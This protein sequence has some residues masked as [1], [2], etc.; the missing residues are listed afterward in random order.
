MEKKILTTKSL[1]RDMGSMRK[2]ILKHV[3]KNNPHYSNL[4][5]ILFE[6]DY[7]N[8]EGEYPSGKDL[9]TKTRLSQTQF[10][11]QLVEMYEDTK[12]DFIYKFPKTSTSFIVKNNGRY[13]VLDIEDLTHIPRIGE[14]VE[15]PFF[16]EEFH[17]DYLFVEDIRHRFSDCEHMIEITLKVGTYDLYWKIRKDEALLK[18]ELSYIDM[19]EDDYK[20]KKILGYK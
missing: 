2:L 15:F 12:G 7:Y 6:E 1:I 16:R 11:K 9:M 14:A 17:S 18:R 20:L 10:R 8:N 4:A 19:F 5:K 13:L 3:E